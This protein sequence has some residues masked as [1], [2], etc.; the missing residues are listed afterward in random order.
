[1]T[2]IAISITTTSVFLCL[3]C[4]SQAAEPK[5]KAAWEKISS[6]RVPMPKATV[7]NGCELM[8][9]GVRCRLLGVRLPKDATQAAS[10]KRFLEL[11]M[12]DYG[13]YFSIYNDNSPVSSKDGV[14]LVWLSGHG[15]GGWAQ[16]TLVQAGLLSVDYGGFEGYRFRVPAKDGEKEFDWKACLK[17]AA[18]SHR[19]GKK[20]NVNFAWPESRRK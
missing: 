13:D 2:R 12:K 10:A 11:Y 4:S 15:N 17:E 18:S 14:P 9:D 1:M 6:W 16:E 5:N 8:I 20:P 7:V 3:V 19:A